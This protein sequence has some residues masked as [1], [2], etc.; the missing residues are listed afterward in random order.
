MGQ[1]INE[2]L[3]EIYRILKLVQYTANTIQEQTVVTSEINWFDFHFSSFSGIG[4]AFPVIPVHTNPCLRWVFSVKIKTVEIG[5]STVFVPPGSLV[6]RCTAAA[7]I[8]VVT[9]F[10]GER[11]TPV[12]VK[13]VTSSSYKSSSKEWSL[14]NADR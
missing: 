9:I 12:I 2:I 10:G 3:L 11:R 5:L 14:Q 7:I 8:V 6:G 4:V 1:K 13:R